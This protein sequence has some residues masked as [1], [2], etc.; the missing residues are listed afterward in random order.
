MY[1]DLSVNIDYDN[2]KIQITTEINDIMNNNNIIYENNNINSHMQLVSEYVNKITDEIYDKEIGIPYLSTDT[3][4]KRG[5]T[6]VLTF[7][8]FLFSKYNLVLSKQITDD[9]L[10]SIFYF[11]KNTNRFQGQLIKNSLYDKILKT[12]FIEKEYDNYYNENATVLFKIDILSHN[13]GTNTIF[14]DVNIEIPSKNLYYFMEI[15][16]LAN[17]LF[18]NFYSNVQNL[19]V[20]KLLLWK[21]IQNMFMKILEILYHILWQMA[22]YLKIMYCYII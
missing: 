5:I 4:T 17:R 22:I 18:A 12:N 10:R 13:Y 19:I 11:F 1:K 6:D 8:L 16:E 21:N 20:E 15:P 7:L 3:T 9:T 2:Y 14:E